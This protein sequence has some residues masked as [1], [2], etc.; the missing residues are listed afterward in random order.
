MTDL[1]PVADTF[2]ELSKLI[3]AAATPAPAPAPMNLADAA[4]SLVKPFLEQK[5]GDR[6]TAYQDGG[7]TWT[8]GYGHTVGVQPGMKISQDQADAMLAVDL[9]TFSNGLLP[10]L[11]LIPSVGQLAAMI[12]LAFNIGLGGF[13]TSTV[14]RMHNAGNFPAAADAFLLWDKEHENGALVEVPGLLARRKQ[15]AAMYL[16]G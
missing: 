4:I 8:I 7:G 9:L 12:S 10:L 1:L 15:E 6:L 16:K 2:D 14:R 3:R 5:E 11:T 13:K